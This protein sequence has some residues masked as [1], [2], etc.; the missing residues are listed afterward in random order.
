MKLY[1][2]TII[3]LV[4][5]A[6][7]IRLYPKSQPIF[8]GPYQAIQC[9]L[10]RKSSDKD[11]FIFDSKNGYLYYFDLAADEFKPLSQKN[12]KGIYFYQ[13]EE[14]SSRLEV[15]KFIGN[16]LVIEYINYLNQEPYPKSITNK[17]INLR[18]LVMHTFNI[19][20]SGNESK[21]IDNCI[22]VNPKKVN[23]SHGLIK[24][25]KEQTI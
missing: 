24:I 2:W 9:G 22:W 13:M 1:S 8:S 25:E 7:L 5:I 6:L 19:G 18:W 21:K 11:T 12:N 3:S 15:N 4:G 17:T 23:T 16:T 14:H 20:S 10:N